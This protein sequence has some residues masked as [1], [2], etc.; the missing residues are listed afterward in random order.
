MPSFLLLELNRRAVDGFY[1]RA[2]LAS[3]ALAYHRT[4]HPGRWVML[5]L[6]AE[7]DRPED[8]TLLPPV[9]DERRRLSAATA[10]A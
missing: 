5:E 9:A 6:R 1:F 8:E 3:D 10:D 2:S 4:E 7:P